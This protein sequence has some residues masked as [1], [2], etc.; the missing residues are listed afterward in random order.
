[1]AGEAFKQVKVGDV[2]EMRKPHACGS[3]DW[4]VIR[5]GA[6]IGIR[7]VGCGRRVLLSPADFRRHMKPSS[8]HRSVGTQ[9]IDDSELI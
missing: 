9:Q 6:D 5:V 2:V 8:Q 3:S 4:L 1:M 7:C